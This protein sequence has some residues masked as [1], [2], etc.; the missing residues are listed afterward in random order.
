MTDNKIDYRIKIGRKVLIERQGLCSENA[1]SVANTGSEYDGL[2]KILKDTRVRIGTMLKMDNVS[3]LIGAGASLDSG[4][5]LLGRIPKDLEFKFVSE[6]SARTTDEELPDWFFL[7]YETLFFLLDQEFDETLLK[8]NEFFYHDQSE[9]GIEVNLESYLSYLHMWLASMQGTTHHMSLAKKDCSRSL[10]LGRTVLQTLIKK[11]TSGLVELLDLPNAEKMSN[12]KDP[13]L[14]HRS[15]I[16]KILN[17]PLNLRR[18]NLF[19]LNYDTLLE[20]GADAEGAVLVDGFVGNL[21]RVFRP[22]SFNLDFYF[23][24]QTTEGKVH[25]YDRAL[26]LYKLHGSLN[27]HRTNAGWDNPYG[28]YSS[29]YCQKCPDDDVMIYPTPLKYGQALGLPYSE[30]FRKFGNAVVQPQSVLFVAGYGFGDEHV[31]AII[32]QALAIPSFTLIVIDPDPSSDFVKQLKGLD[33]E[34]VW[35]ITG[36][37]LGTFSNFVSQ[38]LPDLCEEEIDSKVLR[39]VQALSEDPKG[40]GN[41]GGV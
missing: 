21:R 11:V 33:D 20:Q 18:V 8:D 12:Q 22:E 37:K 7:F 34:R 40:N 4:G 26:H 23:P 17:R 2:Q 1:E 6:V 24:A 38:L 15:F 25:R 10:E 27:W 32:R 36:W 16:K 5:V 9:K 14:A 19:T 3:F 35:L 13:L 31:N 30:L 29:F 39:T 28:L 41:S